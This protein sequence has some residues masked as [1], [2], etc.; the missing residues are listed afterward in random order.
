MNYKL[1]EIK[2]PNSINYLHSINA[3]LQLYIEDLKKN[4]GIKIKEE[5]REELKT[6]VYELFVF[7]VKINNSEEVL[8]R[9]NS[10]KNK[11]FI[12]LEIDADESSFE[13]LN[14][15][16]NN[17][18]HFSNDLL[19]QEFNTSPILFSR[20][21]HLS[22]YSYYSDSHRYRIDDLN[23]LVISELADEL[24]CIS[25]QKGKCNLLVTK[26]INEGI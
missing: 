7:V 16:K 24:W 10:S 9:F 5:K 18:T 6:L 3:I 2:M 25:A 8:F 12:D 26:S 22:S 13:T 23:C 14:N 20:E 21:K 19:V 11:I 15:Y 4:C 1:N 17:K